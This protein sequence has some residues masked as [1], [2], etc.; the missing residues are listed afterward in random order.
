MNVIELS[1]AIAEFDIRVNRLDD[2]QTAVELEIDQ[3]PRL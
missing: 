2:T 3:G 1:D